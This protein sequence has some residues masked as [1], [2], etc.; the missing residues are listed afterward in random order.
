[1]QLA[2]V[3]SY[4]FIGKSTDRGF[5]R[6]GCSGNE[7]LPLIRITNSPQADWRKNMWEIWYKQRRLDFI[8]QF[9][10]RGKRAYSISLAWV[11]T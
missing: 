8:A 7:L 9:L 6:D 4:E 11:I 3:D 10:L 1:M 2:A 5:H